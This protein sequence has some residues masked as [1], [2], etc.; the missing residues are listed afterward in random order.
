MGQRA[1]VSGTAMFDD[2]LVD[3]GLIVPY[4]RAFQVPQQLGARAQ[5]VHAAIEVGIAGGALSDAGSSSGPGRA[6]SSRP[7]RRQA[8]QAGEDPYTISQFGR[9]AVKV[10]AAEALL[11]SAA[12]TLDEVTRWPRTRPRRPA[13]R[14]RWPRRRRSPARS[15]ARWP[16][17]CSCS[18]VPARQT[19]ATTSAVT[20]ELP[21]RMR[22]TTRSPGSTTTSATSYS[23]TCCPPAMDSYDETP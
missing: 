9:L 4:E 18:V 6:R 8:E 14:L 1:T 3:P 12:A 23:T 19:S 7:S 2:V 13:A 16:A 22:A 5:L 10:R 11:A 17:T 15:R 20:G 21:P